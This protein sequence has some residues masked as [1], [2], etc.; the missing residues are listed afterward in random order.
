MTGLLLEGRYRVGPR[1][2]RGGMSTVFRGVDLR[3]DRPV[4]IKVMTPQYAADPTFLAR[5]EREA[6][7][8]AGLDDPHVVGVYDQGQDGEHVFLVMELVD[9]GT[10]RDLLHQRGALSV[11]VAL[12]VLE[13]VLSALAAA[14]AAGLVHRDVKPENVLISARGEVKVADFG[15]VRAVTSTTMATGNVI[16]GTVAYLSPEQVA[17]GAADERS[18][19]YSAGIV[20]YEMLTGHPPFGGDNPLSVAYQH[21]HSDVPPVADEAPGV[22]VGIAAAIDAAT[23]RDALARPVNAADLL[24]RLRDARREVGLS[25]MPVPVPRPPRHPIGAGHGSGATDRGAD[26]GGR[27]HDGTAGGPG[28]Q[29]AG[30]PRV[31]GPRSTTGASPTLARD[32]GSQHT[33]IAGRATARAGR[34]DRITSAE[35]TRSAAGTRRGRRRGA[36]GAAM[37]TTERL[38]R[39]RRRWR[40]RLIV[41]AVVLLVAGAAAF[42]GWWLG[43]RW[44]SAPPVQGTPADQAVRAIRDAGLIPALTTAHD[45][46]T[47]SGEVVSADPTGGSRQLRGA[48]ITLVVSSGRPVVPRIEAGTAVAAARSMIRAADLRPVT[49]EGADVY[50]NAIPAGTVV[51]TDPAAGRD[52]D[53]GAEVLLIRS[54]GPVP[55]QVPPV[56]GKLPEDARNKLLVAGF[57]I[58]PPQTSFDANQPPGTVL[59]TDPPAGRTVRHGSPVSLVLAVS[60]AV[61][62]VAGVP[63]QQAAQDLR[64]AGF[65]VTVGAT[66]FSETVAGGAVVRTDPPAGTRIDPAHPAVTV[67]GS[68]A[69]TVPS[70]QGM[71][72]GYARQQLTDRG[73]TF[74]VHALFGGDAAVVTGQQ[75]DPGTLVQSGSSVQLSA[76]P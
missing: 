41:L 4:A 67:I 19:V 10:L 33:Q 66:E 45:D 24:R 69:V 53:I 64:D 63:I 52:T 38:R 71:S 34:P 11:P 6:R 15:L 50:D 26:A 72:V 18:D 20:G 7:A 60:R 46:A 43:G 68:D 14:H 29:Q 13:P 70:L 39:H 48:T 76:W 44:T 21:V 31:G 32:A 36:R 42:G 2:A 23:S 56:A 49:D 54:L 40:I 61:P 59:G 65:D 12:S 17:T 30:H 8:A 58:G 1:L 73:L 37:H 74:T 25:L 51:R 22:P 27:Q 55:E 35:G 28:G 75:P 16:L 62:D 9:G 5:F 3:L 47:P 57:T